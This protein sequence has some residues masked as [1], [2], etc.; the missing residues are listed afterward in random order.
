VLK[1]LKVLGVLGV[2]GVLKVLGVLEFVAERCAS[3]SPF[4]RRSHG[5]LPARAVVGV[6]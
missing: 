1:V 3:R 6:L 2:L 5:A 4:A